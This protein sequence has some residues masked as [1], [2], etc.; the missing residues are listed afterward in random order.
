MLSPPLSLSNYIRRW[1]FI[2]IVKK[3]VSSVNSLSANFSFYLLYLLFSRKSLPEIGA[4]LLFYFYLNYKL[5]FC[6]NKNKLFFL[7]LIKF[8]FYANL[9]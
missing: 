5:F 8:I 1:R 7:G 4:I 9:L 6:F 3:I 2:R